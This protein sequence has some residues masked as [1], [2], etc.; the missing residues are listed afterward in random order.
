M[1]RAFALTLALAADGRA[2]AWGDNSQGQLGD[3]TTTHRTAP[4]A[5]ALSPG[6]VVTSIAAGQTHSLA[7]IAPDGAAPA[8][9][10]APTVQFADRALIVTWSPPANEG[11]AITNYDIQI[12]GNASALQRIGATTQFRWEGLTNGQVAL[13]CNVHSIVS[14][15]PTEDVAHVNECGPGVLSGT[16]DG[17]VR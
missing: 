17:I 4:V 9:G 15:V 16:T 11:S 12:G 5:V 8:P 2:Y 14:N 10:A 13:T 1:R 3:G 7:L 6:T